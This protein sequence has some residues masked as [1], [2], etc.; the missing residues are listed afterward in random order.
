MR[1]LNHLVLKSVYDF[2]FPDW[3]TQLRQLYWW[4]RY[5][6]PMD[7]AERTA[8][9]RKI[10][11]ERLRL[12]RAGSNPEQIR[13]LCRLLKDPSKVDRHDAYERFVFRMES[14]R[15]VSLSLALESPLQTKKRR[16]A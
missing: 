12:L 8:Q 1:S 2:R 10:K 13:L 14:R 3:S 5:L 16:S 7:R 11:I 6:R 9:Y 4:L 15:F